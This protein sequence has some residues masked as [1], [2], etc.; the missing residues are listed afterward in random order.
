MKWKEHDSAATGVRHTPETA[1]RLELALDEVLTPLGSIIRAIQ[2]AQCHATRCRTAPDPVAL[3]H[4]LARLDGAL[5][6]LET[7][8]ARIVSIIHSVYVPA[9]VAPVDHDDTSFS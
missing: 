5:A 3:F 2:V 6:L 7:G 8:T 4:D 9:G 1:Q